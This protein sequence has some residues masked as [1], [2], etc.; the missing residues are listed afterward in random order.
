MA[1]KPKNANGQGSVYFEQSSERWVAA[2]SFGDGRRPKKRRFILKSD[3]NAA[4]LQMLKEASEESIG[5]P[6]VKL[7]RIIEMWSQVRSD[8][9][10]TTSTATTCRMIINK[11]IIPY[12]GD[13]P[14]S[15]IVP[16]MIDEWMQKIRND[17]ATAYTTSRARSM[18]STIMKYACR[19]E[20]I[21]RNPVANTDAPVVEAKKIK[22]FSAEECEKILEVSS[23]FRLGIVPVLALHLGLRIGEILGLKW[24][25]FTGNEKPLTVK[26]QRTLARGEGGKVDNMT[27]TKSSTREITLPEVTIAA[28]FDHRRY[29]DREK[30]R[31]EY[32]VTNTVHNQVSHSNF[33][34]S[35]L[36]MLK[37]A[38]LKR[39]SF[40]ATRHTFASNLLSSGMPIP[41][42]AATLGHK[43]PNITLKTYAHL[44]PQDR[45]R[46]AGAIDR[47][48]G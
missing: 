22:I 42:V 26:I 31:S 30:N 18:L 41:A 45:S 21:H 15:S 43:N 48:Y 35:W 12:L 34:R 5:S 13:R 37:E 39:T 2:V 25:D 6:T 44:M 36:D 8:G 17:G 46:I 11:W 4:K 33:Y 29:I 40:H 20:I 9:R 1:K 3:A 23:L 14:A 32:V 28:I 7:A 10:V 16:I 47:M 27:K 19:R 24:T 38:G